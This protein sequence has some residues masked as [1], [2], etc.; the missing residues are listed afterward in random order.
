GHRTVVALPDG[1]AY[2]IAAGN[3]GMARGGS[4]D[5]LTGILAAMLGQLPTEEA[6]VT[7]CWLHAAAGDACAADKGEYGMTPTDMIEALPYI[8]KGITE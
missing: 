5:V 8:M 6:V 2:I 7:G 1:R 3:P 4:G